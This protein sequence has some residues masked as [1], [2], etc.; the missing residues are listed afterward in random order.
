[1]IPESSG[2]RR[3]SDCRI[4]LKEWAI[5]CRELEA[6]RQILLL[7]KGGISEQRNEFRVEHPDFLLFPTYEH[8]RA[9]LL[10][11][12]LDGELKT[13]MQVRPDGKSVTLRLWAEA[14]AVFE[15]TTDQEVLAVSGLHCWSDGYALERL[16]WRPIKPLQ[17]VALR[18][19]RLA[20]PF[21]LPLLPAYG[22]CTSW[23]SLADPFSVE[24]A[25]PVLSD[26]DFTNQLERVER[27]LGRAPAQIERGVQHS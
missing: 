7:R 3:P 12:G 6:G 2:D 23:I 15:V 9:D 24:A 21:E 18:V 4:A 1:M 16:H 20:A 10:R 22:G 14:R 5:A 13:V 8:Q 26:S 17:L 25:R 11:P 19:Y 27:A